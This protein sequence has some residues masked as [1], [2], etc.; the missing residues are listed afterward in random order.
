MPPPGG[1]RGVGE[2][3]T[4]GLGAAGGARGCRRREARGCLRPERRQAGFG[5]LHQG[6]RRVGFWESRCR[7][8]VSIVGL[9]A[10]FPDSFGSVYP[11]DRALI[12]WAGY[13]SLIYNQL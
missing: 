8:G 4:S 3:R 1:A 10:F 12:G 5:G 6:R 9:S 11:V 2:G 7:V 13:T